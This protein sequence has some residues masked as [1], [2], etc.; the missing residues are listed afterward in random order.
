MSDPQTGLEIFII[1]GRLGESIVI[2]TP[3]GRFGVVDAYASDWIDGRS[4]P[5]LTRLKALGA[6]KLHFVALTHPHMDHFRGL[7][8]IFAAYPG[9]VEFF[10]RPPWGHFDLFDTFVREFEAEKDEER[11]DDLGRSIPI[12]R[13]LFEFA[14]AEANANRLKT[15]TLQNDGDVPNDGSMLHEAEH[16]FSIMCLGP[17]TGVSSPYQKKLTDKT[18]STVMHGAKPVWGGPH[19]EISAVLA[20]RYGDWIGVL[21]GD[22]EKPSWKDIIERRG[23]LLNAARFFK[24]SH[25][26]SDTGSFPEL[27]DSVQ[28]EKCETVVTCYFSQGIPNESGLQYLRA[29]RFSLHSTN[30]AL[31]THLYK[32]DTKPVPVEFE[33]SNR[34]GEVRVTVNA[35]GIMNVE[36]TDPAGPLEL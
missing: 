4:N 17:S 6:R 28:S 9:Q 20:I 11:R 30:S 26:G 8:A 13:R 32:N 15:K 27:W 16:D 33:M 18:V 31:A 14:E 3:R 2:R 10:W 19:N 24:V 36:Y 21:G 7:P 34:P 1:G 25:H 23:S 35:D 12:L 5:T 22:T 29:S